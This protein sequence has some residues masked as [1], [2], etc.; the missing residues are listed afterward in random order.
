MACGFLTTAVLFMIFVYVTNEKAAAAHFKR[1]HPIVSLLL[2]IMG[3]YFVAYM[4]KSLVV[5]VLGILL[6]IAG[7]YIT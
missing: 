6:P 2:I 3:A 1:K 4:L 5:F 7:I